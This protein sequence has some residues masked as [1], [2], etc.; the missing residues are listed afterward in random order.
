MLRQF[1]YIAAIMFSVALTIASALYAFSYRG[2]FAI[3]SEYAF[4]AIPFIVAV[5]DSAMGDHDGRW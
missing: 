2:Y 3:G 4:L 5:I 1:V